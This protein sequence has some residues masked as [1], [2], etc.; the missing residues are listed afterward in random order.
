MILPKAFILCLLF[1]SWSLNLLSQATLS[2]SDSSL[3]HF[4]EV[5]TGDHSDVQ[6]YYVEGEQLEGEVV[7]TADAP[8]RISLDC[9]TG[10]SGV[11]SLEPGE[12]GVLESSRIF[13]RL[14]AEEV[15]EF[16]RLI[17]HQYGGDESAVLEVSG[18]G[19]LTSVPDTYY[20]GISGSGSELKSQLHHLIKNHQVQTYASLWQHF[21]VTDATFD[22]HVWDIYSDTPCEEPPYI[23]VFG[24]DQDTGTGGTE[25]GDVYNREHS[26]PRS[27]FGGAVNPMNTDLYH[28]YP[29]DKFVN[30]QRAN[31][32]FG[33]VDNPFWTSLN[34]GKL[35]ANVAG[36]YTGTAF[37]PIDEY[38][39]DLARTFFY[40]ITRYEDQISSWTYSE[41]GNAMFDHNSHPGYEPWVIQMLMEWHASDPVS[42]KERVRNQ[43]VYEIQGNRNPFVDHPEWVEKIWGDT[44]VHLTER[45]PEP[46]LEVFPNPVRDLFSIESQTTIRIVHLYSAR[47]NLLL[48]REPG[49]RHTQICLSDF[50]PGLY[51]LHVESKDRAQTKKL[52]RQ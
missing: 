21:T 20:D 26:M 39:G 15:G 30:A 32:P 14:F 28:I 47:G 49:T 11:L 40:M 19:I 6:F 38:K 24:D 50:P 7:I 3:P 12:D 31:F 52:I 22:G 1:L 8:F 41:Y 51:L 45:Y 36:G 27:W 34:G 33:M 16:E 25:E 5:W 48:R 29:V 2:L 35:G 18:S 9:H 17:T 37:E 43:R 42:Q 46:F 44:T 4:R 13:V 23:Y 10:F